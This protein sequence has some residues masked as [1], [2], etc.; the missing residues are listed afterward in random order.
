MSPSRRLPPPPSLEELLHSDLDA[1]VLPRDAVIAIDGPAGSGKSSTARWLADHYGLVYIDTGAMY[2]ALTW[3]AQRAGASTTDAA[4]LAGLLGGARL[5]LKPGQGESV[6]EWNDRDISR[7]IRK[8][9]VDAAVSEVSSHA[10]VRAEMVRRQQEMGRSGGVVME[11]RDIGSVVFPLATAKIYLTASL[12]DR[13]RRRHRQNQQRGLAGDLES[14]R[15]DLEERDRLDSSRETSPL[16]ISP[17]AIVIDSSGMSLDEQNRACAKA[18][19]VNPTLDRYLD[20]DLEESRQEWPVKYRLAYLVTGALARFFGMRR[21]NC[22]G[23]SLPRGCIAAINHISYWDPPLVSSTFLRYRVNSIA[24]EE[25]FRPW[26]AGRFLAFFDTIPIRRKG[27]D[28][29]AFDRATKSLH[30]G[31]SIQL[32]PEGT[33][34]AIGHPGPVRNGLGILVQATRAPVQ[35][36]FIRGSYGRQPGGSHLSPLE[37]SYGPL[38]RWHGLDALLEQIDHKEA[39]R[40][41]ARLCEAAYWEL[42][43]R[44]FARIPQTEFERETGRKQLKSFAERQKRVFGR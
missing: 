6:I 25:L 30:A 19:L 32:Y 2:R 12:D 1:T 40:R 33:R 24:K 16:T 36:I 11:G 10:E 14:I 35:P 21:I 23:L 31:N 9:E 42:Q 22:D 44:S 7:E 34:R 15:A 27:Y 5:T 28:K 43:A 20:R 17:D 3:A 37:V 4:A 13:A 38:L 8:P 41:I 29:A 39:S 18:C 26:P